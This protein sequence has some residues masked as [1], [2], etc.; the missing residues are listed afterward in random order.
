MRTRL[1]N[2]M[3]AL[4]VIAA[5]VGSAAAFAAISGR[6]TTIG[7][8]SRNVTSAVYNSST[9]Q[10]WAQAVDDDTLPPFVVPAG[11]GV[12]TSWTVNVFRVSTSPGAM[13]L[14]LLR[15]ITGQP[16]VYAVAGADDPHSLP[17]NAGPQRTTFKTRIP[18]AGGERLG[19][20]A[21]PQV[22]I[23]S[24]Y[25]T[26]S[27]A[28]VRYAP[29]N[30]PV[31]QTV[32]LAGEFT[33][34]TMVVE[35][36]V[37]PDADAD[38]YGDNTQDACLGD[39]ARHE[40]PCTP[41]DVGVTLTATPASIPLN[42]VSA[43]AA[44]VASGNVTSSGTALTTT[45]PAG[46]QLVSAFGG[47][48]ACGGTTTVTCP[49][50]DVA[51]GAPR[52]VVLVVRGTSTGTLT[53]SAKLTSVSPD[54]NSANDQ[55]AASVT[56]AAAAT[57]AGGA[58]ACVVP[59]LKRL[60]RASATKLLKLFGCRAGKVSTRKP[61][62][63]KGRLRKPVVIAFSPRAGSRRAAGAFVALTLRASRS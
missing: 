23:G 48:G 19:I 62:K 8:A 12:V 51:P 6:Q 52:S 59:P 50:G 46:L 36:V 27:S 30:A 45:L 10:L 31:G 37:E 4:L 21:D 54:P 18:V 11:G 1:R 13:T 60:T 63:G 7:D 32:T 39:G 3:V 15:P 22:E 47:A 24:T 53:G 58:S 34:I 42:S 38:G 41:P 2:T 29:T 55:A 26:P 17:V 57:G 40:T 28:V 20:F 16:G 61:R 33:D 5:G 14:K 43:L 56:V 44:T 35:A 25:T 49:V 9:G